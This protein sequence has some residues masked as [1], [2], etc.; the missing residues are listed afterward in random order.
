MRYCISITNPK[1]IKIY[2]SAKHKSKLIENSILFY[3][4]YRNLKV[5]DIYMSISER[6][7]AQDN[8]Q[9]NKGNK[10][11]IKEKDIN[12]NINVDDIMD[13]LNMG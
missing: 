6:L 9:N 10:K 5:E 13:I 8:N 7:I 11:D 1:V 4:M 12:I 2:Q 3:D